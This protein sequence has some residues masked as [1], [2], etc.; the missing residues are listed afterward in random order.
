[1]KLGT[2][3]GILGLL[4]LVIVGLGCLQ[5]TGNA[6]STGTGFTT[7]DARMDG[8]GKSTC[9]NKKTA[10]NNGTASDGDKAAAK[11][12]CEAK[13]KEL[14][15]GAAPA[16]YTCTSSNAAFKSAEGCR[17]GGS[18]LRISCTYD[19]TCVVIGDAGCQAKAEAGKGAKDAATFKAQCTGP[20][21]DEAG[22]VGTCTGAG[23]NVC[24]CAVPKK[25]PP[26]KS[27][28]DSVPKKQN[29]QQQQ[30]YDAGGDTAVG[31][32]PNTGEPFVPSVPGTPN[33]LGSPSNQ[34]WEPNEPYSLPG[35]PANEPYPP[36]PG[37][38]PE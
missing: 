1:M 16:G 20:C 23:D 37:P 13:A 4:I 19:C 28:D 8:G 26:K 32:V 22:N 29:T 30:V 5:A 11:A 9:E 14:C 25:E 27:A 6:A 36:R 21:Q 2:Q 17:S 38:T 35:Q 12:A 15:E 24:N 34:A 31:V 3:F 18:S 10:L 33:A 7:N